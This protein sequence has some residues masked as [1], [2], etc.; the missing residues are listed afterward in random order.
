ME[1]KSESES[2][3]SDEEDALNFTQGDEDNLSEGNVD[4]KMIKWPICHFFGNPDLYKCAF[5]A[6]HAVF[7]IVRTC[8]FLV[9]FETSLRQQN[10]PSELGH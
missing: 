5:I 9:G 7:T 6:F 2:E 4:I 8:V 3:E 1:F 10:P